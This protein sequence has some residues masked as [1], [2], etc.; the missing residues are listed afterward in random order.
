M[1]IYIAGPLFSTAEREFN[2]R[3]ADFLRKELV[4]LQPEL[5]LPQQKA[6][7][8]A[9][10]PDFVAK[11]F[12]FCL[13]TVG[14]SDCLVAFLEGSDAD[15]GTCIEL[16]YAFAKEKPIVG[17]RTDFRSCEDRGL[18]LMVANVCT[19]LIHEPFQSTQ[20]LAGK[21]AKILRELVR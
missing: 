15:S 14:R 7:E 9:G 12:S 21:T 20:E 8:I 1:R 3:F 13:E 18:N 17:I 11:T 5:I 2:L 16:G 19:H 4:D 6:E 10:D